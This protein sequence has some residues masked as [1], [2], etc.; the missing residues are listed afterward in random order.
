MAGRQA[1]AGR[2][3]WGR[4]AGQEVGGG[5]GAGRA[6][7]SMPLPVFY[8][9]RAV[10]ASYRGPPQLFWRISLALLLCGLL[11]RD[12]SLLVASTTTS[13]GTA[14]TNARELP[15]SWRPL[16]TSPRHALP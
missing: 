11:L 6:R 12:G 16:A 15:N 4:L 14:A 2:Q 9:S 13:K 10:V 8:T 3:S 5:G 7:S 1:A